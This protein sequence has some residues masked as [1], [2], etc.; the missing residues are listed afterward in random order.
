ML[1]I[2]TSAA[3]NYIP[4]VINARPGLLDLTDL[5]LPAARMGDFRD[6]IIRK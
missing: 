6:F 2:F 5:P 1:H 4:N 3:V